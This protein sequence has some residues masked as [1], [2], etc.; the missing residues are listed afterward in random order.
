[1]RDQ[2]VGRRH[3]S[4]AL[5]VRVDIG[6]ISPHAG[7]YAAMQISVMYCAVGVRVWRA[8]RRRCGPRFRASGSARHCLI[9]VVA[10]TGLFVYC[11]CLMRR[12]VDTTLMKIFEVSP[13]R[14]FSSAF[15]SC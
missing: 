12:G 6:L 7:R 9:D 10:M 11:V 5:S 15:L 1:M 2:A 13:E 4:S 3:H 14:P 8:V